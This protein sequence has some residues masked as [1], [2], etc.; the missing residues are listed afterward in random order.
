VHKAFGLCRARAVLISA[1]DH[2]NKPHIAVV[3][4]ITPNHWISTGIWTIQRGEKRIFFCTRSTT[5]LLVINSDY[6]DR[7]LNGFEKRRGKAFQPQNKAG[8]TVF[9]LTENP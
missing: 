3:T 8:K 1:V 7:R 4:N 2:E 5:I 9:S 6:A